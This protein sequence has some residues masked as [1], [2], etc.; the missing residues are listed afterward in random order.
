MRR[1]L[2]ALSLVLASG[3]LLLAGNVK[4]RVLADGKPLEG[5]WVSDGV[6]FC[7]TDASGRFDIESKKVSGMVYITPPTGWV[8]DSRDGLRPDFWQYLALPENQEE[9]HD[10]MLRSE[11]QT[12]YRVLL[13]ADLHLTNDPRKNDL[14]QFTELAVPLAH[15][16]VAEAQGSSYTFHL[17][18]L[19]H[20]IFWPRF[21]FNEA[22]ALRFLQDQRWPTLFTSIMGNHDHDGSVRDVPDVDWQAGWIERDCWG[23]DSWSWDIG[24][25]HW[26]F[27]DNIYYLNE[28]GKMNYSHDFRPEQIEWLKKDLSH[29]GPSTRVYLLVHCPLLGTRAPDFEVKAL[30]PEDQMDVVESLAA[31]FAHGITCFAGHGHVFNFC[32]SEKYSHILSYMLPATSG[33]QWKAVP[34][35][36]VIKAEGDGSPA[37]MMVLDCSKGEDCKMHFEPFEG[38]FYHY[39]VYDLNEVGKAYAASVKF[40]DMKAALPDRIDYSESRFK[41]CILVNYWYYMTGDKVELFENGKPLAE[42]HWGRMEEP[43]VVFQKDVPHFGEEQGMPKFHNIQPRPYFH[44]AYLFKTASGRS[45]LVLR[46]TSADGR[47]LHEETIIRPVK[48]DPTLRQTQ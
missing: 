38:E 19:T 31:G 29:V 46:I 12:Y 16:L 2:L 47:V 26:V 48:F 11:D 4:G 24:G 15:R 33:D 25:D 41:N 8:P 23:P 28:N 9:L 45:R 32:K 7:R 27:M 20:D 13:P 21:G 1:A 3:S 34:R 35:G 36:G 17:G 5:V 43:T 37:G 18:D 40:R 42:V 22:E 10:F 39:R 14:A 6:E 44:H 30:M